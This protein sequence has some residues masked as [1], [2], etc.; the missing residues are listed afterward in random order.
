MWVYKFD[1]IRSIVIFLLFVFYHGT[2]LLNGFL[3]L[4]IH[5]KSPTETPTASK[6]W[7]FQTKETPCCYHEVD[8]NAVSAAPATEGMKLLLEMK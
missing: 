6:A 2:S 3:I 8:S 7:D 1:S 4:H 5:T